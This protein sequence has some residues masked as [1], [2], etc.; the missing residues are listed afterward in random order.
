MKTPIYIDYEAT[1]PQHLNT[2]ELNIY[3]EDPI[4]VYTNPEDAEVSS[5][6][7]ILAPRYYVEIHPPR[8]Q[9]GP[10]IRVD[11]HK[12]PSSLLRN[13]LRT[14]LEPS[15]GYGINACYK[16]KYWEWIPNVNLPSIPSKKLVRTEHWY[17]PT[18][19]YDLYPHYPFYTGPGFSSNVFVD[20]IYG[21]N[22]V[23]GPRP[24]LV[25]S[26]VNVL[27][28]VNGD[29]VE[30]LITDV[31]GIYMFAVVDSGLVS[32]SDTVVREQFLFNDE[33]LTWNFSDSLVS[34]LLVRKSSMVDGSLANGNTVT[35]INYIKPFH[36]N[37]LLFK[38]SEE[39]LTDTSSYYY[40]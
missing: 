4:D 31:N 34:S 8:N 25:S 10:T 21:R 5:K 27:R 26:K 12:S 9:P 40:L 35:T 20:H 11:I 37:Q 18:I 6:P 17:V 19:S 14:A 23:Y 13:K 15:I 33:T 36:P 1:Y 3:A 16:V 30:D 22:Y 24:T 2:N 38:D 28:T 7:Y 39:L 29:N 32:Y